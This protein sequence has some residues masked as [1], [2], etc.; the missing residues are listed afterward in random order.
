MLS[1]SYIFYRR[2]CMNMNYHLK[3][4]RGGIQTERSAKEEGRQRGTS[5]T[6]NMVYEDIVQLNT[7][8]YEALRAYIG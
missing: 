8:D 5:A 6:S 7:A 2:L 3:S 4:R 1:I